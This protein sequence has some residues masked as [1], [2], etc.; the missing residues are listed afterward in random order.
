M[1]AI[2]VMF[3]SLNLHM[4]S[5]YGCDWIHTPNFTRLEKKTVTFDNFYVGSM[6]CMP[7][8]REIHT[9]RYNFLHR[10]WGPMEP[11][12]D[13]MPKLLS[14]N[15]VY[16]HLV[17]DH[18][19]YWEEGGANYHTKYNSFEF[20]RGQDGDGWKGHL[21]DDIDIPECIDGKYGLW[22]RQD[23]INRHYMQNEK[24]QPIAGTF[25]DGLKFINTN[26]AEDNWFLQIEAFDPHEPFFSPQK[27]K[28]LYPHDYDGPVFDWPSYHRISE[29]PEQVQHC[30]YEY[31]ALVSM[32][33]EYL[34]RVL[35]MMDKYNMWDDTMLIVNTDHG[36]LLSEHDWWGKVMMP[37][38][39]EIAHIPFFIW[40]PRSKTCGERRN[41]LAQTI[42]ICPTLLDFFGV[43][44]PKDV[45]GK[46]LRETVVND[47]AIREYA[48]FGMHGCHVNITDGRYVYMRACSG[49]TEYNN[50]NLGNYTLMPAHMKESFALHELAEAQLS[51]EFSFTKGLRLLKIPG[52]L[53]MPSMGFPPNELFDGGHM[54]FDLQSDSKQLKPL[55]DKETEKRMISEL[56]KIMKQE[57]SPP[58]QYTRLGLV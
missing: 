42:D 57:D 16:T 5:S 24:D 50:K 14:Q 29:T 37:F 4:L 13:S 15:G 36:F 9:G 17:S 33:D 23:W 11:Y 6:P 43:Q 28:D 45:R 51:D 19:H 38:Y 39:N 47:T 55:D 53:E 10:S 26:H 49:G 20:T 34:G 54:L 21:V 44:I 18:W 46:S 22:G 32:C 25:R 48:L 52:T 40:D 12:D 3:D 58:E 31:A 35:D 27:Y 7:A 56:I 1:K 2:M 30:I 41:A 8:R